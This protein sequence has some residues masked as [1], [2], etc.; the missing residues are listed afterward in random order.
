MSAIKFNSQDSFGADQQWYVHEI[1]RSQI[2]KRPAV[3]RWWFDKIPKLVASNENV[4]VAQIHTTTIDGAIYYALYVG[5]A[6]SAHKRI[7]CH[8]PNEKRIG[9][10]TS[11]LRRTLRS[12]LCSP[13]QTLQECA[14]IVDSF[15]K[16]H[17]VLEWK[18]F[19]KESDAK[20]FETQ[21]ITKEYYPLNNSEN[22]KLSEWTRQLTE[23]RNN[24]K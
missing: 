4:A 12:L 14:Q 2:E 21:C 6:T 16:E 3:Y 17:A 9:F 1:D 22:V 24:F 18:Y 7:Y 20:D 8:L 19:D 5:K 23:L 10:K 15:M 11:T 13:T